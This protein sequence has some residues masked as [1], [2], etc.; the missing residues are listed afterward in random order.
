M[1]SGLKRDLNK[2]HGFAL[3]I[4]GMIGAGIFV[5]TG[6]AG[7]TAGPSVPFGYVVLLPILLSS[8]LAY[9]IFLSTPLGQGPGGAYVHISQTFKS[10]FAGFFFMWFQFIALLGVMAIMALSFG[11][12]I[13][14]VFG[15][16]N[17]TVLATVMILVFYV[18]NVIGV[19]WFGKIQ[20]WMS[21]VLFVAIILLV[22]PGLFAIETSNFTP[23]LPNGIEGFLAILP[24]LFFAYFGFEQLA[25]AGGEMEDPQKSMPRTMIIGSIATVIIYFLVSFV[26]F[27]VIPYD[28]LA[29]SQSAMTDVAAVYLPAWGKWIVT[30]GIIMAF[31]TTLNSLVMVVSRMMFVFAEEDIFPKMFSRVH[32]TTGTPVLAI[33]IN[34]IVSLL[35]IWTGTVDYL[36]T[37]ALQGMFLMYIGHSASMLALPFVR[38]ELFES[39]LIQPKIPLIIVCGIFS[40]SVLV[41]FSY[42][43]I[44]SV[45]PLLS[46]WALVG[47]AI[48][49][50]RKVMKKDLVLKPV[51]EAKKTV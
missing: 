24:S 37:M 4:G 19:K 49:M 43:L 33:T 36:I 9:L 21:L 44:L 38:K 47:I 14:G 27:G 31:A 32:K 30:I 1:S 16:G 5:V 6:E 10:K 17:V 28:Q 39:A 12:Y 46:V 7:A 40:L 2:W 42:S 48:Y 3:M 23:M 20:M 34:T 22:V 41:Y 50:T 25:Q 11:E 26:A 13:V 35:L 45:L 8:A 29:A 18:L 51:I 15:F